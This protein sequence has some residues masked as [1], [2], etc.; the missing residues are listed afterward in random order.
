MWA[1]GVALGVSL[2][3]CLGVFRSLDV[4]VFRSCVPAPAPAPV[5]LCLRVVA[6][7][8]VASFSPVASSSIASCSKTTVTTE[9]CLWGLSSLVSVSKLVSKLATV[10]ISGSSQA[11]LELAEEELLKESKPEKVRLI[12]HTTNE[13]RPPDGASCFS[14]CPDIGVLE[15]AHRTARAIIDFCRKIDAFFGKASI[16]A[17]NA[18]VLALG[19]SS[20]GDDETARVGGSDPLEPFCLPCRPVEAFGAFGVLGLLPGGDL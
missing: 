18:G 9:R 16:F 11:I 1:L 5:L 10:P 8:S 6:S 4:G 2:N 17:F 19:G 3:L 7:S 13:S 14:T 12:E 20:E 15:G